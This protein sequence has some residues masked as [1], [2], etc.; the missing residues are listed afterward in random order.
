MRR[1]AAAIA[2]ILFVLAVLTGENG[3]R[4][5]KTHHRNPKKN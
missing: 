5:G 1:V 3:T 4:V 2:L